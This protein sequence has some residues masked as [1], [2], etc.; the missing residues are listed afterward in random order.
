LE[1]EAYR[2]GTAL[3][4]GIPE[5]QIP[6]YYRDRSALKENIEPEDVADAALFLVSDSAAKI[7]GAVLTVDGGV[8]FV[9]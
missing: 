3:R 4:Y 6:Q 2:L 9:R 8:A 1:D 7:T 5:E